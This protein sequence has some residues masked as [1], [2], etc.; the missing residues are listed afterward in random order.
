MMKSMQEFFEVIEVIESDQKFFLPIFPDYMFWDKFRRFMNR[1]LKIKL[2]IRSFYF[3]LF[4][5]VVLIVNSATVVASQITD[6]TEQ[7]DIYDRIDDVCLYIYIAECVLKIVGFGIIK[8]FDDNWNIFDFVLVIL[9][10]FSSVLQN[11][12]S[13]IK[14]AKSVKSGRLLRVAKVRIPP[15]PHS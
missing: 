5:F 11:Y 8:Y 6:D 3:E 9:S 2:I 13:L 10:L 15:Y 7:N 12:L 1:Y 14:S 4:M